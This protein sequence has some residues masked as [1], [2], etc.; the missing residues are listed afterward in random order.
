MSAIRARVMLFGIWA[1]LF[2]VYVAMFLLMA[3]FKDVDVL[4]A[5]GAAWRSAYILIPILS[6]FASFWFLSKSGH[7]I[8]VVPPHVLNTEHVYGMFGLTAVV[9]GL[10][11]LYFL[12]SVVFHTFPLDPGPGEG[13]DDSVDFGLNL[14]LLLSSLAVL[15]VGWLLGD[16]DL[17]L[18]D[19]K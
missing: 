4:E 7:Q 9:H 14:L 16:Q 5:R 10:V 2:V 6:A 18:G 8:D 15:P 11:L 19:N 12:T 13:F 17:E 1:A 3:R